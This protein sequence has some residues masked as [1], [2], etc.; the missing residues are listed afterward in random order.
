MW[1]QAATTMSTYQAVSGAAV[2]S[3]PQTAPAPAIQRAMPAHAGHEDEGGDEGGGIVDN[4]SGDPTQLSWWIN[5]ITQI[6]DTFSRDLEEFPENPAASIAQLQEDIPLLVADEIDH[7]GEVF[8]TFPQLQAL[9]P[10]ALTV[11][12]ANLG[13]AGAAGLSGLAGIQPAAAPVATVPMPAAPEPSLAGVGSSPVVTTATAPAPTPASASAPSVAPATASAAAAPPPPPPGAGPAAY[14]YLVG[15]PGIGSGSAMSTSAQR[16]A[17]DPDVLATPAA[18]AASARERERARRRRRTAMPDQ[19]RG[20]R[21]EFLD[22]DFG[23]DVGPDADGSWAASDRGAGPLG[24]AGTAPAA[25]VE[26]AG[27]ATLT[28]DGFGG[29]PVVPMLPG[30]WESEGGES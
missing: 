13:F 8:A 21:Y 30:V 24:F 9:V 14:P 10:L 27:L 22:A 20:Y 4:D 7:L 23:A 29:G 1:V 19:H 28:G 11:P 17:P 16:K 18:A 3:A 26:A 25:D 6:T 12:L 5:R 2:G 15:G